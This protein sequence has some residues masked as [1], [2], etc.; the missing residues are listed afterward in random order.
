[1][2]QNH[3]TS[4]PTTKHLPEKVWRAHWIV[5]SILFL[6]T[7]CL[8]CILLFKSIRFASNVTRSYRLSV[9][10]MILVLCVSR[11]IYLVLNPYEV[12]MAL[13]CNT[14]IIILRL[15]YAVGQPSIAT[16]FGLIHA[17]FLRVVKA[18]HYNHEPLL[19]TSIILVIVAFYFTF[20]V[21]SQIISTLIPGTINMF[22]ASAFVAVVGCSIVT[23]TVLYSGLSIL[24]TVSKNQRILKSSGP[25]VTGSL[26]LSCF[27]GLK[28]FESF[29]LFSF[30]G[31]LERHSD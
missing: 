11:A 14:P 24:F 10:I 4:Q 22:L 29:H 26:V 1:M 2:V 21:I 30:V 13:A 17:S 19:K 25:S 23:I 28:V 7:G 20:G 31:L 27:M 15:I 9:F 12:N 5:F 18:K 16:G 6:L 3:S 8:S